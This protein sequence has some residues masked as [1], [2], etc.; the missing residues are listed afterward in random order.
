MELADLT[1]RR[2]AVGVCGGISAYKIVQL[3]SYLVQSGA[4]VE[5]VLTDS[6][7]E[8]VGPASFQGLTG[9]KVRF[10]FW[11]TP[12]NE[13]ASHIELG[14]WAE[15]LVV[16]PLTA[17]TAAKMS[18]GLADNLLVATW[19]AV[20]CPVAAAPAM[21][22]RMWSH[23]AVRGSMEKLGEFGVQFVGPE[24]GHMSCG[25]PGEGR[26]A[27]PEEIYRVCVQL[28]GTRV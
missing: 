16:A 14:L 27:E 9:R 28:L 21:N 6:A 13:R 23:P 22:P 11:D 4:Q 5:V 24:K 2:I 25:E 1:G 3:V 20:R 15:L 19:L 17:A 18:T 26:M 8:F 10:D 7:R 12:Q